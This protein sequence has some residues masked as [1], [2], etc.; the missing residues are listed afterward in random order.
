MFGERLSSLERQY[1]SLE[2]RLADPEIIRHQE[3]YQKLLK[4]RAE[5]NPLIQTFRRC[6]QLQKELADSQDL[7]KEDTD[8][9]LKALAREEVQTLKEKL[10]E[11][12]EELRFLLLPKDPNDEKNV[13]LEIRADRKS[14]RL[15][16]SHGYISY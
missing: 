12:E 5:L 10:A 14:T 1:D 16:S 9:E 4:E 3:E 15:N 8:E 7:L 11:T 6:R 13:L 2:E